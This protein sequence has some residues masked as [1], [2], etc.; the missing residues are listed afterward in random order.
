MAKGRASAPVL[1]TAGV[2]GVVTLGVVGA[3]LG[4]VGS[5]IVYYSHTALFIVQSMPFT[6][7]QAGQ[8]ASDLASPKA[9]CTFA[10]HALESVCVY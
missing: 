7:C 6:L 3:V 10:T 1:G 9:A 8:S 4:S 2:V 5:L